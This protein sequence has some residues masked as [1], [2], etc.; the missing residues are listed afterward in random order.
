MSTLNKLPDGTPSPSYKCIAEK[1]IDGLIVTV[2]LQEWWFNGVKVQDIEQSAEQYF[3]DCTQIDKASFK[4]ISI[5][6]VL[7]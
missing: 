1:W 3:Y 7:K 5:E 4:I 6:K 2:I